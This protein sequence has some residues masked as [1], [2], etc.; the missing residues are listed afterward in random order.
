MPGKKKDNDRTLE[1]I[2]LEGA[3]AETL[4]R[5]S[6]AANEHFV[7]FSGKVV[8]GE[9]LTKGLK[10]ISEYKTNDKYYNQ[11]IK[12]QAGF[13]AELK[14]V[15]RN[16]ADNIINGKAERYIRSDDIGNVNDQIFDIR[17]LD[18]NGNEI[19][20]S[21]A[22]MKFVGNSSDE[23]LSK[24]RSSKYRKYLDADAKLAIPDDYYDALMG[25][26]G[27]D[28]EIKRLQSQLEHVEKEGNTKL[29]AEKK[30]QIEDCKKIKRNL[31]KSGLSRGEAIE[32]RKNPLRSTAKDIGKIA[33][34]AGIEQA[35]TGAVISGSISIV[36]NVVACIKGEKEIDDAALS[37]AKDIGKGTVFSY[38]T[39]FSGTV[40][41]G[42]MKNA[43]SS[44]IRS[45][46]N[47]NLAAGLVAT[48][49]NVGKTM[50]RYIKGDLTGAQCVEA[51]GEQGVGQIGTA[52]YSTIAITAVQG[53]GS[54]AIKVLAGITGSTLGYTAAVAVYKELATS[55]KDH[56]LAIENRKRIETECNEA[57][58]MICKYRNE[59]NVIIEQYFSE[60]YTVF[61][62]S[63]ETMDRAIIENDVDGF[64]AGNTMIQEKLGHQIQFRSKSEFEDIMSSDIPLKL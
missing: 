23:L 40:V 43:S 20:G 58:L 11:N 34:K 22:Q 57:V 8:A 12:Q 24:L 32:A 53:S 44:Y 61:D 62:E 10:E 26:D 55:L 63:F 15:A 18:A 51:L 35:K 14:S 7:A 56:E 25:K 59:M 36:K 9:E 37:V 13:S 48:T 6:K 31:C 4:D 33:H 38:A 49:V 16:N 3:S 5:Y 19:S 47:T 52:V 27:I 2:V 46:S 50:V 1:Q 30:A 60:H 54:V 28:K 64:I 41:N 45:L 21:A 29:I 17:V 39:A 42:A